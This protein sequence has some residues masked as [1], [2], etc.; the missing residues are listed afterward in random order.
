VIIY[1]SKLNSKV[2][3]SKIR[4][5][6]NHNSLYHIKF[7]MKWGILHRTLRLQG[8][9]YHPNLNLCKLSNFISHRPCLQ[10]RNLKE[11]AC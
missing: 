2:R 7:H 11:V 4:R 8:H 10:V 9:L 6:R 1:H 3:K 5:F